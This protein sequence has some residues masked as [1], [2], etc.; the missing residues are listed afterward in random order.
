MNAKEQISISAS[1][2]KIELVKFEILNKRLKNPLPYGS[3]Y[4]NFEFGFELHDDSTVSIIVET[5]ITDKEKKT[6][7]VY[8]ETKHVVYVANLEEVKVKLK[9]GEVRMTNRATNSLLSIAVGSTRG[10]YAVLSS[11]T[12]FREAIIPL[13]DLSKIPHEPYVS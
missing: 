5:T 11:N 9:S 13:M 4:Y 3:F 12:A 6:K 1:I 10:I 8:L 7:Y 2:R